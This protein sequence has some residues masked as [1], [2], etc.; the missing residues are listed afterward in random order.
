M[1]EIK[2]YKSPWKSIKLFF[3]C[4]PF[5]IGGIWM[6]SED[7]IPLDTKIIAWSSI[8]FFGLGPIIAVFNLFDRRAQIIINKIG[9]FDRTIHNEFI[10][11]DIIQNA[12]ILNL[13]KQ[14]F[15]CLVIDDNFK[16]ST[17]KGKAYNFFAKLNET[18]GAQEL[19]LN[20][21]QIKVDSEKLKQFILSMINST[22]E[23]RAKN[24]ETLKL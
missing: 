9:V 8:L 7:N 4:L 3:L 20:L 12:Y 11:W 14:K 1:K 16:P 22:E 5:I 2:L 19:N 23:Q 13:N 24:F 18:I 21:S 10:N 6:L 17:K 15:I